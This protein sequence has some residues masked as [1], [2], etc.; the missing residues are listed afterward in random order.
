MQLTRTEVQE[1]EEAL[2]MYYDGGDDVERYRVPSTLRFASTPGGLRKIAKSLITWPDE[3]DEAAV[4]AVAGEL[5]LKE[6]ADQ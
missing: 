1:C 3:A 5:E 2:V 6:A 4:K